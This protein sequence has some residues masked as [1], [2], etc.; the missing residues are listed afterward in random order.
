M[1]LMNIGGFVNTVN[2]PVETRVAYLHCV[3]R[4]SAIAR[5]ISDEYMWVITASIRPANIFYYVEYK[6][7][8]ISIS[9]F[10]R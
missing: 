4:K 8:D 3:W 1:F 10:K 7:H 6:Y 5:S 9:G 2:S